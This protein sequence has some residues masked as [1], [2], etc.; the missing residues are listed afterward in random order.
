MILEYTWNIRVYI[1][2]W[3]SLRILEYTWNTG[4]VLGYW[5][6]HGILVEYT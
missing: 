2:Y 5:S 3:S 6:I 1:G 4:V